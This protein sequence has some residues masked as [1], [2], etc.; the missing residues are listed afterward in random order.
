MMRRWLEFPL[1]FLRSR[2]ECRPNLR[3]ALEN[4]AWL[5][6]DKVVRMGVG[7]L[8]GVWIA[9]Y[10]GPEQFGVL[11]YALAVVFF[12]Q[13]LTTLGLD[14]VTIRDLSR[15]QAFPEQILGS[16]LRLRVL[17]TVVVFP[18]AL[19]SLLSFEPEQELRAIAP[20]LVGCLLFSPFDIIAL[21]FQ[22]R[23]QSKYAVLAKLVGFA[24]STIVKILL[25]V[26]QAPLFAFA[27][28]ILLEALLGGLA[29]LW[30]YRQR[31]REHKW[32]WSGK[33]ASSMFKDGWPILLAG[34][35]LVFG[36]QVDKVFI[37]QMVGK[38]EVGWYLAASAISG[39]FAII[40]IVM[41]QGLAPKL[42]TLCDRQSRLE[43]FSSYG[44]A[45]LL[46][47]TFVVAALVLLSSEIVR[48]LYG[49][50]YSPSAL[51]LGVSAFSVFFQSVGVINDYYA[52]TIGNTRTTLFRT[53]V[54]LVVSM[55][56]FIVLI[57][58][59]GALGAAIA[60]LLGH[61]VSNTLFIWIF[62]HE[63]FVLHRLIFFRV[64]K[65]PFQLRER[66]S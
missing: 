55:V 52:L 23:L 20:I 10:L 11:G 8:V 12:F 58:E 24:T 46:T 9:R 51:I 31:R 15:S 39:V 5:F 16:I 26:L 61:G 65:I 44:A 48:V 22:S 35:A 42:A 2:L 43:F 18:L 33:L 49:Q 36:T 59:H 30:A 17:A 4:F 32:S 7:L 53:L 50:A 57:P 45:L 40:P 3:R 62:N 37:G 34:V 29:L 14:N 60:I 66:F 56:L 1:V 27:L 25:L 28:A 19:L 64:L 41:F 47:M 63:V 13:Y 38:Q 54:G 21:C 6:F